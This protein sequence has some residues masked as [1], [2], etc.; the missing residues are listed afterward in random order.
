MVIRSRLIMLACLGLSGLIALGAC[1]APRQDRSGAGQQISVTPRPGRVVSLDYCADQFVIKLA[2]RADIAAVSGDA[3]HDFS[4]LREEAAGLPT[5]KS[6]AEAVLALKPDLV[7]RSYG[8]GPE[9]AALLQRAGIQVHQIGWG[10]DFAS[11]RTNVREAGRALGHAKRAE[12]L[13]RDFDRRLEAVAKAGAVRTL[14]MTSGGV[15]TGPGSMVD[16]MMTAAGLTNFQ[17]R[18]GWSPI[19]LEALAMERPAM[20]AAAFFDSGGTAQERWSSARHPIVRE[21]MEDIPVARLDGSTMTCGGWFVMD[22]VEVLA[23]A[24]RQVRQ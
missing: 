10:E 18:P 8:G 15:T 22:A 1:N 4:Y 11:V 14:Y 16:L 17:T 6:T 2:D 13:V 24:G 3:V 20:T 7:V 19:P 21:T 5:V 12:D 23:G 9:L